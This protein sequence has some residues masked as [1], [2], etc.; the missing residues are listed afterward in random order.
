MAVETIWKDFL[1][2]DSEL[3]PDVSIR[4]IGDEEERIF[5]AHKTLLAGVSPVFRKQFFGPMKD[6]M[7]EV[8]V[9]ETTPEAFEAMLGY[10]YKVPGED[11]L[12]RM[13]SEI[14]CPQKIFE[15][16]FINCS[17]LLIPL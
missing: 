8:K 3:P 1:S 10:I 14:D 5:K 13:H 16:L 17:P 6:T 7:E 12:R 4:V 2:E 11:T 15:L 9:K